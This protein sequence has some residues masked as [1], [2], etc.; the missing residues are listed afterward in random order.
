VFDL[1]FLQTGH[2]TGH[3]DVRS[4]VR[5]CREKNEKNRKE[6]NPYELWLTESGERL[7][8]ENAVRPGDSCE[9]LLEIWA[10]VIIFSQISSVC[11]S[12]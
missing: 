11:G 12:T 7:S 2:E 5:F 1:F 4:H 6:K 9:N 8:K 10:V 3:L